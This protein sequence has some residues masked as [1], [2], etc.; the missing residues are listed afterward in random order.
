MIMSDSF[1]KVL[2]FVYVEILNGTVLPYYAS[3]FVY[4]II[5]IGIIKT[6]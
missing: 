2:S 6:Q 1:L 5:G 3:I 4:I